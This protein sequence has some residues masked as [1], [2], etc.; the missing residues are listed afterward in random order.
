MN[1]FVEHLVWIM[2][3]RA[4]RQT[5]NERI[6]RKAMRELDDD[7]RL[8]KAR[9]R[10]PIDANDLDLRP[11]GVNT[12]EA[13]ERRQRAIAQAHVTLVPPIPVDNPKLVIEPKR[14]R[15]SRRYVMCVNPVTGHRYFVY[16]VGVETAVRAIGDKILYAVNVYARQK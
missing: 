4:E 8:A 5:A 1:V 7:Q 3:R 6:A 9:V 16:G 14:R 12:P 2:S 10:Y 13:I 11:G 15:V